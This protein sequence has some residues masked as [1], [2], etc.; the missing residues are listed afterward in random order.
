MLQQILITFQETSCLLVNREQ[1]LQD[2]QSEIEIELIMVGA[3]AI[4][5]KLQN[6]LNETLKSIYNAGQNI[7]VI[8]GDK[9]ETTLN[10]ATSC[11]ILDDQTSQLIVNTSDEVKLF[12]NTN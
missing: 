4:E 8:T 9:L 3:T 2:L 6:E 12:E 7:W 5:D 11:G 1:A 10:I